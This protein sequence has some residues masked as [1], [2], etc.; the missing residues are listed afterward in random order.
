MDVEHYLARIGYTG[1]REP[2]LETLRALHR[3][4]LYTVPFENLDIDLGRPIALDEAAIFAK[5]VGRRRGGFCYELNGLFAALLRALGFR[6]AL[7]AAGVYNGGKGAFGPEYDHLALRVDLD[8]P[9]LADVGFGDSFLYPLLLDTNEEQVDSGRPAPLVRPVGE[10][11]WQDRFR[12]VGTVGA[13]IMQRRDW[14]D[15]WRDQY[16]LSLTP[17]HWS[18]FAPMCHY[19]QTSPE[20][21]FTRGRICS[22]ATPMGRVSIADSRLLVTANGVK[23]ETPLADEAARAVAL[24]EYC[25][26]VIYPPPAANSTPRRGENRDPRN[27]QSSSPRL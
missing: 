13:R 16:R 15:E 22:L 3:A 1:S 21:G 11:I 25:G 17:R 20:S 7:L 5:I 9:W 26:I 27:Q 24:R 14:T 4:Q 8:R 6:V 12:I 23:R 19:H 18:E 10:G 2:T